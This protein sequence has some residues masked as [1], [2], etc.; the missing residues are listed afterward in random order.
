MRPEAPA[1]AQRWNHRPD[2]RLP[3]V[4][5]ADSARKRDPYRLPVTHSK[6][7]RARETL[8]K[9][10]DRSTGSRLRMNGNLLIP[11]V[12]SC[13]LAEQ[14]NHER[15]QINQRFPSLLSAKLKR[16]TRANRREAELNVNL[17]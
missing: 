17:A 11:F 5:A 10:F 12:V 9:S 2:E 1:R 4:A 6:S 14:S 15:N 8:I 7:H 13:E 3:F 16:T